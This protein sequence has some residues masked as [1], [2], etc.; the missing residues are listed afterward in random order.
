MFSDCAKDPKCH[1]AY[2]NLKQ[3]FL[4]L[5]GY[6]DKSPRTFRYVRHLGGKIFEEKGGFSTLLKVIK[7][8]IISVAIRVLTDYKSPWTLR[9]VTKI[10]KGLNM[11]RMQTLPD[12]IHELYLHHATGKF[13]SEKHKRRVF[14]DSEADSNQDSDS[15]QGDLE[16]LGMNISVV[17]REDIPFGNVEILEKFSPQF[18]PYDLALKAQFI[19]YQK[20]CLAWTSGIA[21]S[22]FHDPVVSSI[23]TLIFSG[24]YDIA[25]PPDW[26][27]AAAEFAGYTMR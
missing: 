20:H 5:E 21:D 26:A 22:S 2:P 9:E 3:E 14:G 8:D 4:A 27:E 24:A 25:T 12:Y 16:A 18:A 11:G 23:P 13:F 10:Q 17:C 19:E 1:A 7:K 6:L 15:S